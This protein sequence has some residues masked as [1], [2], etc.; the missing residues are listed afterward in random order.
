MDSATSV[1]RLRVAAGPAVAVGAADARR[2]GGYAL[3]GSVTLLAP[4]PLRVRTDLLYQQLQTTGQ[5]MRWN[6]DETVRTS[7]DMVSSA[8]V[9]VTGVVARRH[10]IGPAPYVI[11]GLGLGWPV[12][13]T[14][15]NGSDQSN[16]TLRPAWQAGGGIE[17]ERSGRALTIEARLQSLG[18]FAGP[19]A[20]TTIPVLI[21]VSF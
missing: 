7:G 8:A 2:L 18:R 3:Q 10:A 4:A 5:H 6:A 19:G 21:G 1:G 13:M 9:L 16:R 11:G 20:S 15:S 12:A 17:W 14:M